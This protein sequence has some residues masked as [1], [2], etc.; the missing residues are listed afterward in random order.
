MDSKYTHKI[1]TVTKQ[2]YH[3]ITITLYWYSVGCCENK[4]TA[5][6][7][8]LAKLCRLTR[9]MER[10]RDLLEILGLMHLDKFH[11]HY[12]CINETLLSI[13]LF[14]PTSVNNSITT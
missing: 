13:T 7:D 6:E 9:C 5:I 4:M 2:K 10:D 1:I 11:F 12:C 8:S 3:Y 14:V